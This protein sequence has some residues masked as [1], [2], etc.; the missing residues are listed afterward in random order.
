VRCSELTATEPAVRGPL[1]QPGEGND[2]A[3]GGTEN[4][5]CYADGPKLMAARV[6]GELSDEEW[7]A[8]TKAISMLATM[9]MPPPPAAAKPVPSRAAGEDP[10]RRTALLMISPW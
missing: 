7:S 8:T 10:G 2:C 5:Q 6:L 4:N 1:P 9:L 3:N